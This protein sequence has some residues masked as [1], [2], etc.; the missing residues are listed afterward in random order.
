MPLE[1]FISMER[2]RMFGNV[3]FT[4]KRSFAFCG[5]VADFLPRPP[6]GLSDG[7]LGLT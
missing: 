6:Y 3:G 7:V 1:L 5:K 4:G 2:S